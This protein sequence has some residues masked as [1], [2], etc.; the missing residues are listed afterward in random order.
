M[1]GVGVADVAPQQ[2]S[3]VVESGTGFNPVRGPW[4]QVGQPD[5]IIVPEQLWAV[6]A[7]QG[8]GGPAQ[9]IELDWPGAVGQQP[10][11]SLHAGQR[12]G[13]LVGGSHQQCQGLLVIVTVLG[14]DRKADLQGGDHPA[15][16]CLA[17]KHRDHCALAGSFWIERQ[18]VDCRALL[19]AAAQQ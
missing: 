13:E 11:V 5:A 16:G 4:Q 1:V 18:A 19:L 8:L 17:G 6:G 15:V 9:N 12:A 2:H 7:V 10:A 14:K 3:G